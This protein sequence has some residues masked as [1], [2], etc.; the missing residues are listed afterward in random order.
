MYRGLQSL[1]QSLPAEISKLSLLP[2]PIKLTAL[3]LSLGVALIGALAM[4]FRRRRKRTQMLQRKLDAKV[5]QQRRLHGGRP[6]SLNSLQHN[7]HTSNNQQHSFKDS[8]TSSAGNRSFISGSS[9]RRLRSP[10]F[11][12]M[13]T[14]NGGSNPVTPKRGFT[15]LHAQSSWVR[16]H[17]SSSVDGSN[18][19][20]GDVGG[21]LSARTRDLSASLNSLSGLSNTSSSSTITHSGL[22]LANMSSVD[23]CQLGMENLSL[24]I[25]YWED[26]IMKLSYLDDQQNHL[27]IPDAD[28]ASLQHRLEN[29]LDLAYRMQ[30]NYERLCERDVENIAL[31]SAL[32]VFADRENR[33]DKSFDD[34]SSDQESFVS[35]SDM[36]NLADLDF[37]RDILHHVPLYEAGMLELKYGN[38]PCRTIRPEMVQC[39]SDVEF[40][41]KLHGIRLAFQHIFQEEDKKEWFKAMGRRL[42]GDLLLKADKDADEFYSSY[43]RM[44]QFISIESNWTMIE[45]ELRGR[46]V[47][48]M[49]FYD[50]VLD[51]ILMDAFDDLANPPSSVLAVVQNR[52]LSNGF[53]ETALAT[54]VWSVL[55]AKRS[56]LKFN[57]GFIAHFYSITEQTSPLLAWG[58]L[59]PES[60]LKEMCNF[61]KDQVLGFIRDIFSFKKVRFTEVESLAADILKLAE[62]Q[63]DVASE[64]LRPNSPDVTPVASYHAM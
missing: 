22:D 35:C 24:A 46:G 19:G 2:R 4:F 12:K 16:K 3:S 17:H 7:N 10:H 59:G 9:F 49:S 58:F 38:V 64:R 13:R 63:S 29:L 60:D 36:A 40:L 48:C 6:N 45:E 47:R 15:A 14:P 30:D 44:M 20:S 5:Q 1:R 53:K 56:L 28:T 8:S 42:I 27:A 26:A 33:A 41:A 43:D 57:D 50:I 18:I 51:F 55:K 61:F 37:N 21:G 23:L 11:T 54:A 52:W 31:E 62:A 34:D 25:S 32:S 39:L